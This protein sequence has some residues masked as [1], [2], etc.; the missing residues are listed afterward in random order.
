MAATPKPVRKL[1]KS[2]MAKNRHFAKEAEEKMKGTKYEKYS[3]I[4]AKRRKQE[5]KSSRKEDLAAA[6]AHLKHK[7]ETSHKMEKADVRMK[8]I[9]E[10]QKKAAYEHM[11][12]HGG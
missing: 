2:E 9:S 1:Y 5:V 11:K 8:K 3:K 4:N 10:S 12:K 6:A 7:S